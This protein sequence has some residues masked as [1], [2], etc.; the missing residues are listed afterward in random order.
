L[1]HCYFLYGGIQMK[2]FARVFAVGL[3]T[4]ALATFVA[5]GDDDTPTPQPDSVETPDDGDTDTTEP[6]DDVKPGEDVD[7]REDTDPGEEPEPDTKEDADT[8]DD[9]DTDTEEPPE[10]VKDCE[11]RTCGLDPVCG[12]SCGECDTDGG[13][14]CVEMIGQCLEAKNWDTDKPTSWGPAGLVQTLDLPDTGTSKEVC[15]DYTDDGSGDNGLATVKGL[16]GDALK[17]AHTFGIIFEFEDVANFENS[18]EFRLIG[19]MGEPDESEG[20][21]PGDYLINEDSYIKEAAVPMITFPGSEVTNRVLTT[22]KARFVLTVPVK[23]DLVISA[24]LSDAQIKGDV[25]ACDDDDKC[26][27]GVVI[28]NGVLSG[29]L[30]KQDFQRVADDLVA[31]CDA[32]PE[33][34]RDSICGYLKPATINMVL[35]L[36]DLHKKDDGTY[37]PKN[38]EEGFPAN[39]LSACVQFT[40]SKIVIKGFIPEEPAA[41]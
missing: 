32:Q 20:A 39:A 16:I 19:L 26:A 34:E 33:D 31:W 35:G 36:F 8:E 40:L 13:E 3:M 10:C 41:E 14:I 2:A 21:E 25:V 11:G 22:P 37:V 1:E 30:T 38:P 27:D 23:D 15:F 29:I 17:D 6:G 24:S 5:C 4:V 9:T 7:A 12:E 18:G 28:E